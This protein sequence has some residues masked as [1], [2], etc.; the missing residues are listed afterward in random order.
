MHV[1]GR[2]IVAVREPIRWGQTAVG[3]GGI[4]DLNGS[5]LGGMEGSATRE[6]GRWGT[7]RMH[8]SSTKQR[9]QRN[10][11]AGGR[12]ALRRVY[13]MGDSRTCLCAGGYDP[14]ELARIQATRADG[15]SARLE[16]RR[17][18]PGVQEAGGEPGHGRCR[19]AG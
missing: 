4:G 19:S 9:E 10:K 1:S 5:S 15:R 12:L 3:L 8:D 13:Q 6:S 11:A 18:G 2:G 14:V 7:D 16:E 17:V